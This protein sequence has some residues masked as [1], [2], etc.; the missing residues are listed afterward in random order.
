MGDDKLYVAALIIQNENKLECFDTEKDL[1]L[2]AGALG[3]GDKVE[4]VYS[5]THSGIFT[6]H[7]VVFTDRLELV[8]EV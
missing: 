5:I 6:K 8:L 4:R 2:R 7:K 3:Y 1:L